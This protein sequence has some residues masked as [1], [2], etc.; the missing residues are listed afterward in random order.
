VSPVL[1]FEYEADLD[2][3]INQ[4]GQLVLSSEMS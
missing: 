2:I 3:Q 4:T 1:A